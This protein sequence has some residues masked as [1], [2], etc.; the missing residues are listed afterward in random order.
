MLFHLIHTHQ[1]INTEKP[2]V[3][4]RPGLNYM[5]ISTNLSAY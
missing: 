5:Y 4:I 3:A 1:D 2:T